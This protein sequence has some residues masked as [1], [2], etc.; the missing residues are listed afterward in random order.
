MRVEGTQRI[1]RD[2]LEVGPEVNPAVQALLEAERHLLEDLFQRAVDP[3]AG[4]R[5]FPERVR[6]LLPAVGR[7]SGQL[8]DGA[9]SWRL[10]SSGARR[11][12]LGAEGTVNVIAVPGP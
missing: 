4:A 6:R 12:F 5:L 3:G 2:W 8:L 1:P 11:V 9:A 10:N 7:N